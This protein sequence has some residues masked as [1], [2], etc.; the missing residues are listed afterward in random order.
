MKIYSV[1]FVFIV[2]V[3][4]IGTTLD[5]A[6]PATMTYQGKLKTSQG[7]RVNGPTKITFRIYDAATGGVKLWEEVLPTV[8]VT[9][10]IFKVI[11]GKTTSL[12]SLPFDKT[13]YISMEVNTDGEMTPRMEMTSAPYAMN[14]AKQFSTSAEGAYIKAITTPK[15]VTISPSGSGQ[16][17]VTWNPVDGATSYNL[18]LATESGVNASNYA[19][20]ANGKAITGVTSP[21]TV[22]G[23][24]N[25]TPYFFSMASV[26][27][28][29]E[30]VTSAEVKATPAAQITNSLGMIFKLIS[31]G[32]FTMGCSG[33]A[34]SGETCELDE[35]P[36]HQVTINRPFYMQTTEVTQGQW[37][38]MTGGN[39]PSNFSTCGNTCPVEMVSWTD[40]QTFLTTLNGLGQGAYR[41]PTEAEWEYAARAGTTTTWSFGDNSNILGDHA[42]YTSNSGSKS[43]PVAQ[44]LANVWGLYDMYGNVWEWVSDWYGNYSNFAVVDPPGPSNGSSRLFRG[45]AW[46]HSSVIMRSTKR[47]SNNPN[48]KYDDVGFR[49]VKEP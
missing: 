41:L 6:P 12:A 15:N 17:S 39:N 5:A 25:G 36:A 40:I 46:R 20:K 42:W 49:L 22:T 13:Y 32:T 28:V 24:T 31:P 38:A 4:F 48:N 37:K 2:S 10:G 1:L 27:P 44:K 21:Y 26:T 9:D 47:F 33:P 16:A 18:Y 43:H 19:S 35:Q 14:T 30:S 23:L 45:A 29:G 3:F 7:V 8:T 11:L 34:A